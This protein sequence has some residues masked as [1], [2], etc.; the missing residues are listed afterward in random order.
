M[1]VEY[2]DFMFYTQFQQ[3]S[4]LKVFLANSE[5]LTTA[6]Q[7]QRVNNVSDQLLEQL[8]NDFA[9]KVMNQEMI[10]NQTASIVDTL[11]A[12][13][14]PEDKAALINH[15]NSALISR[16]L[17]DSVRGASNDPDQPNGWGDLHFRLESRRPL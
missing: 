17:Q 9:K 5:F 1:Y 10:K 7:D 13:F 12:T 3:R 8:S 15:I 6:F 11:F 16:F 14:S 2:K 4:E